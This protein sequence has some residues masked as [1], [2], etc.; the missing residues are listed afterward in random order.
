MLWTTDRT[1]NVAS[2]SFSL[3]T[4]A[5]PSPNL[6]HSRDPEKA[7]WSHRGQTDMRKCPEMERQGLGVPWDAL[8]LLPGS[9]RA[10]CGFR[11][12]LNVLGKKAVLRTLT[13][14]LK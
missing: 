7:S 3:H 4:L 10:N 6:D 2:S 5:V 11:I 12:I 1:R 14:L 9:S 13:S 8:S